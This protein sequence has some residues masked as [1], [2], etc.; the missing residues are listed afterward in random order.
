MR[1]APCSTPVLLIRPPPLTDTHRQQIVASVWHCGAIAVSPSY[2][3]SIRQATAHRVRGCAWVW[4]WCV[5]CGACPW[6]VRRRQQQRRQR[7][8]RYRQ[9]QQFYNSGWIEEVA[10]T[11]LLQT[12][13]RNPWIPAAEAYEAVL[14]AKG[15]VQVCAPYPAKRSYCLLASVVG[16]L[17]GLLVCG[18][19]C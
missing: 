16:S 2:Y 11:V 15:G 8:R 17:G 13:T 18:Y 19:C 1:L 6:V 9:R 10:P 7:Q 14:K 4:L 3:S 12:A 5:W